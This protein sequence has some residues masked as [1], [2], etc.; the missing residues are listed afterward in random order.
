MRNIGGSYDYL[1]I[2]IGGKRGYNEGKRIGGGMLCL[3]YGIEK[4]L[5]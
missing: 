5:C 1:Y 3:L 2:Y 4:K